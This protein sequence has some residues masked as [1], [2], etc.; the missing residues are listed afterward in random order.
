MVQ[1]WVELA[2]QFPL[3]DPGDLAGTLNF[4]DLV[5]VDLSADGLKEVF[6]LFAL[7]VSLLFEDVHQFSALSGLSVDDLELG[8]F[9]LGQGLGGDGSVQRCSSDLFEHLDLQILRMLDVEQFDLPLQEGRA[10]FVP[11]QG[12]H[13]SLVGLA[14]I[15]AVRLEGGPASDRGVRVVGGGQRVEL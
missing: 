9:F 14:A 13:D 4:V 12:L 1:E 8:G 10:A 6:L 11:L 3:Q 5:F 7:V 2:D 15:L